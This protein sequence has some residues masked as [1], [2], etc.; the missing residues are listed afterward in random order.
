MTA[1]QFNTQMKHYVPQYKFGNGIDNLVIGE[2]YRKYH[3]AGFDT[4]T[5]VGLFKEI[6]TDLI[7]VCF[8]REDG[9]YLA[10]DAEMYHNRF[11]L[12]SIQ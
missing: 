12:Y 2:T 5:F 4:L 10:N 11:A 8:M 7:M 9:S 6:E 1:T 3:N